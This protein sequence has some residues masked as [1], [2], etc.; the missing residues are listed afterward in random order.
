MSFVIRLP[1][2]LSACV[3]FAALLTTIA[4]ADSPR[5]RTQVGNN[6]YVGPDETIAEATCFG[7][8]VRI[9]GHVDGDV[10]VFGGRMVVEDQGE[11]GGDA[12][13]F[14][15][16]VRL[17]KSVK[18]NGDVCVFGGRFHRD[19]AASIGGDI[20]DFSGP[21]WLILIVG[22]PFVLFGAF[23]ALIIFI[24]RRLTRP[25]VPAPA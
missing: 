3:V 17:D 1:L 14:G 11:I 20:V 21:A 23:V 4:L 6:I 9:R 5:D 10:T 8:S 13:D 7:C 24:V 12:V 2:R 16:S 15:G 19:P 25:S 18:V 22:L